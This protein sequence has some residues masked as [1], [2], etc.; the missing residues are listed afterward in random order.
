MHDQQHLPYRICLYICTRTLGWW[1]FSIWQALHTEP[2]QVCFFLQDSKFVV[3][4]LLERDP[5]YKFQLFRLAL[6]SDFDYISYTLQNSH[7]LLKSVR[8]RLVAS[9]KPMMA[10]SRVFFRP[11]FLSLLPALPFLNKLNRRAADYIN[12]EDGSEHFLRLH[13]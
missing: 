4:F 9:S 1:G 12:K 2:M 5:F 11:F 10:H 7:M 3:I 13:G 8:H 6:F